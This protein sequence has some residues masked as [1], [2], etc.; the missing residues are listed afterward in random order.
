[1]IVPL[2]SYLLAWAIAAI[3]IGVAITFAFLCCRERQQI[4]KK[5]APSAPETEEERLSR[6]IQEM[7]RLK[8]ELETAVNPL[9]TPEGYNEAVDTLR[10]RRLRLDH[11]EASLDL[12]EAKRK[13]EQKLNER[14]QNLNKRAQELGISAI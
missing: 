10:L 1:M 13:A 3:G 6:E 2:W 4:P 5:P 9:S 14:E 8:R 11:L 7:R 12:E